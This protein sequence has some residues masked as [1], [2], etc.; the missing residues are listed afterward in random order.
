MCLSY[1][2]EFTNLGLGIQTTIFVWPML[3]TSYVFL[4]MLPAV[5]KE[6]QL[7]GALLIGKDIKLFFCVTDMYRQNQWL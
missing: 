6:G 7:P 2:P 3:S 4:K 5:K 1:V